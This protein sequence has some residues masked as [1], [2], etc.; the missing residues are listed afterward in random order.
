MN[1]KSVALICLKVLAIYL[2]IQFIALLPASLSMLKMGSAYG[3]DG[4]CETRMIFAPIVICFLAMPALYLAAGL[5]ML[6]RTE[7]IACYLVRDTVDEIHV[8]GK[9]SDSVMTL[10]FQ[11][12]GIYA[13]ITWLPDFVQTLCRTILHDS[14]TM[15]LSKPLA[16]RFYENWSTLITPTIGTILGLLL[17]FKVSGLVR[18]IKLSRPISKER[19]ASSGSD[20]VTSN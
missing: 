13:L 19:N 20:L 5:Y 16:Q 6:L 8:S 2:F 4:S 11:C 1:T 14:W 18:L 3:A 17:L 10:A 15:P 9:I 7:K 12:L